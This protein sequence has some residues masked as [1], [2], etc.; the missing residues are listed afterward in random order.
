MNDSY[1]EIITDKPRILRLLLEQCLLQESIEVQ[2]KNQKQ[3]FNTSIIDHLPVLKQDMEETDLAAII[4]PYA[5]FSYLKQEI[6]LLLEPLVS[7]EAEAQINEGDH[8]LIRFFTGHNAFEACVPFERIIKAQDKQAAIQ[9]GFPQ[10]LGVIHT[11]KQIRVKALIDSKIILKIK[12][13]NIGD[14]KT[15][16]IEMSAGGLSFCMPHQF[17]E[18]LP[19]N[20]KASFS[21][22]LLGE[23]D[24]NID[25]HVRH[26]NTMPK[27]ECCAEKAEC[28]DQFGS[29][30]A[31]CG[32]DFVSLD[33]SQK[34]RVNELIFFIHR[35]YLI[36]EKEDLI[37]F[38]QD[39]EK[40]VKDK[41]GQL[42]EKDIQ[43]LEM[44]RIAGIGTLAA[45]IAHEINNPLSFVKSS[46]NFVKKGVGKLVGTSKFW[47]DQPVP[48]PI[49]KSYKEYLSQ[50][51][52][53]YLINSLDDK[54]NSIKNGIERIMQIVVNLKSFSRVD[55]EN[56][57]KIDINKSIEEAVKIITSK[58][59]ENVEFVKEFQG[60]PL[61]DCSPNDIHQCLLHIIQNA[62]DAVEDNGIIKVSSL[63]DKEDE[64]V[65]IKIIDNGKGMSPEVIRQAFNPFF[66]TKPVGSGTGVG[67]S[68]IE[69]IIKRHGGKIDLSSKENFGTTVTMTL[70]VS[71]VLKEK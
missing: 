44:D 56:I 50:I 29:L 64:Q 13:E 4:K 6:C 37:R 65:V 18:K 26:F 5:P 52:F 46:I 70:P 63:H 31:V 19:L 53:E 33:M 24:L 48:E 21:I 34:T 32:F 22:S 30:K 27:S 42:R 23:D 11:R 9:V 45:G 55:K 15:R 71:S 61:I 10:Q 20:S 54:F 16:I 68:I 14:F 25:G 2:I 66:T 1:K 40:Q 7:N 58:D 51:N 62:V 38:N 60:I 35:E 47:D 67:L 8:L 57:G 17:I 12:A 43:L 39:L 36:K 28:N 3:V 69:R 59:L 49:M 41:T